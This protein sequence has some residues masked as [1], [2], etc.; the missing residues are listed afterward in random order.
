MK[1]ASFKAAL[2]ATILA[3]AATAA[4]ALAWGKEGH[5]VVAAIAD[6][7]L[8]PRARGGVRQILGTETLAEA[9]NW[10]DFMRADPDEF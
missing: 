3:I 4:P 7:Y 1:S 8:G 9:S 10:P 5:R 2:A 6:N